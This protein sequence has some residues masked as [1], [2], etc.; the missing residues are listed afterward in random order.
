MSRDFF[1]VVIMQI[2][3]CDDSS[4]SGELEKMCMGTWVV[5]KD[6]DNFSLQIGMLKKIVILK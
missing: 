6:F 1:L 3:E 2:S 4:L 5:I